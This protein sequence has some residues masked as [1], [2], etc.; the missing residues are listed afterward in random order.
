M[1]DP[2]GPPSGP[3]PQQP[4]GQQPYGQPGYGPP[5]GP[6]PMPPYGQPGYAPMMMH[7]FGQPAEWGTRVLGYLIDGVAPVVAFY[8]LYFVGFLIGGSMAASGDQD[9]ATAGALVAGVVA[10]VG[11]LCLAGFNIWNMCYRR[12]TTGQT[13]GQKV[14]KIRT[15]GEENGRPLGFGKAFLRQ[16]CHIVD[17]L[18]CNIGF[19]AP[20]WDEK[21]QT[22]ADKIMRSVVV[23]ADQPM[24]GAGPHAGYGQPGYPGGPGTPG[25]GMPPQQPGYGPPQNW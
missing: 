2:Y 16:L 14:V 6:Q 19:L 15:V 17:S 4:Y 10:L 7:P 18:P 1:T 3:H 24:T 8:V 11:G 25:G 13:L 23:R 21:N 20:L 9:A 5:S 22:W 12:G